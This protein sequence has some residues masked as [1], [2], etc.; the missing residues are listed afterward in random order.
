MQYPSFY[1]QIENI[2]LYDPLSDF[3][4]A[5]ENGDIEITYLDCVKLAGHSCPTVAGAYLIALIGLKT[6]YKD[7]LPQ[8]GTIHVSMKEDEDEGVTGVICNV[9]S[10][11][12]GA[13]GRGGFKGIKDHFKRDNLVRYNIPME[14]EVTLTRMDTN[15]SISISYNPSIIPPD[16]IM[17]PLMEKNLKNIASDDEKVLFKTLWQERVKKILLSK[18]LWD[19]MIIIKRRI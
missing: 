4:G 14:G 10:F 17:M 7:S 9:I 12:V 1:D 3:L 13:S 5:L 16:E 8:R 19:Q 18:E 15:Q 6:L 2:R 11:I